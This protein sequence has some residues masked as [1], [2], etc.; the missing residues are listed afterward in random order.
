MRKVMVM[1]MAVAVGLMMTGAASFAAET[2][3]APDAAAAPAASTI[4]K[5]KITA[6]DATKSTI[7]IVTDKDAQTL[8]I[9]VPAAEI[10]NLKEGA[11]VKVTLKAGTTDQ[12]EKVKVLI[13]KKK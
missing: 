3:K 1:V 8:V 11:H 7:T 12:A 10:A 13:H 9:T 6:I 2:K 5:G 4:V